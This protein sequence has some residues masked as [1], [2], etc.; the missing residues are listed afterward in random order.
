MCACVVVCVLC[1]TDRSRNVNQ[2]PVSSPI[3]CTFAFHP[4]TLLHLY[5]PDT[6]LVVVYAVGASLSQSQNHN[7]SFDF[8][9]KPTHLAGICFMHLLVH[10]PSS[11]GNLDP[12]LG[13]LVAQHHC[14]I[15]SSSLLSPKTPGPTPELPIVAPVDLS[16]KNTDSQL[17]LLYPALSLSRH[18]ARYPTV[19]LY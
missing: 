3:R 1:V 5:P 15:T 13:N 14:T 17:L 11:L 9:N 2:F 6:C 8:A 16:P 12:Y 18:T 10:A 19:S 7:H 4:S